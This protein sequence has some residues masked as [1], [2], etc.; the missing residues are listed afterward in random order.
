MYH[1]P[2][3]L[4]ICSLYTGTL[5]ASIPT[6]DFSAVSSFAVVT[7]PHTTRRF[8][9]PG[10]PEQY[11][12][13]VPALRNMIDHYLKSSQTMAFCPIAD[14]GLDCDL[15]SDPRSGGHK[16]VVLPETTMPQSGDSVGKQLLAFAERGGA[17]VVS[18]GAL[19]FD[20]N[21]LPLGSFA[22][23]IGKAL[24]L[25]WS[26]TLEARTTAGSKL[27]ITKQANPEWWRLLSLD[28][29]HAGASMLGATP[30]SCDLN[31]VGDLQVVKPTS[32]NTMIL[33]TVTLASGVQ[34]PLVT[35][36][37]VGARG[38]LVY[39]SSSSTLVIEA[40]VDF[41]LAATG[42]FLNPGAGGLAGH[43]PMSLASASDPNSLGSGVTA[44][45]SYRAPADPKVCLEGVY[46]VS[47]IGA[48]SGS[49]VCV[50]MLGAS[51]LVNLK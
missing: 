28:A 31:V 39:T 17:V 20:E 26:G 18:G 41:V 2:L 40:A 36:T 8:F 13:A 14:S 43:A 7:S 37:R 25:T 9:G 32:T 23:P 24:G 27:N 11:T 48:V 42:I 3:V 12:T 19:L 47:I 45:L 30:S 38:W 4:F 22:S 10:L 51:L 49:R 16:I 29:F 6:K 34:V 33:A 50:Q 44:L 21:G 1:H 35:A 46:R 5:S 15:H